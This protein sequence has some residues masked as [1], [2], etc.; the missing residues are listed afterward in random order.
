MTT[1]DANDPVAEA[2]IEVLNENEQARSE[3]LAALEGLTEEQQRE[4]WFGEWSVREIVAHI[5]AWQ[6]GFAHALERIA[7]G[8]RPEIPDFDPR[9]EDGEDHFNAL[10]AERNRHLEWPD[11]LAHL[12]AA[13]ER[14]EAAVRNLIG[15]VDAE[16]Y[17]VG[18]TA[19]RLSDSARHDREHLPAI[20]EWRRGAGI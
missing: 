12:R 6:D 5:Y 13:K 3:L 17:E 11:L 8:E 16:R 1:G 18:R 9:A 2:V 10:T 4:T 15:R 7:R 19:R 20:L 14:H